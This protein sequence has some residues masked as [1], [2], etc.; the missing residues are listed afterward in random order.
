MGRRFPKKTGPFL[1]QPGSECVLAVH[2]GEA[3]VAALEEVGQLPV[4]DAE[5]GAVEVVQ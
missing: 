1:E 2:V 4:V 3:E 5:E